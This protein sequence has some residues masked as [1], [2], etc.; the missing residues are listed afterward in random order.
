MPAW[1]RRKFLVSVGGERFLLK[2]AGLGRIGEDKLAMA[3]TL[4]SEGLVPEPLGLMHGF[5]VERWLEDAKPLGAHEKPIAE[6]GRYIAARANALPASSGS[7]A[8][9]E[10][11]LRMVRRN[12]SLEFGDDRTSALA[13]LEYHAS[14]L[15]RRIVRRRTDNKLDRHEW[16]RT[17]P[18]LLIK[19]D[20]LDHHQAHDLIGCQDVAW[21]VAGAIVEFDLDQNDCSAC[22][23][24]WWRAASK[25][26]ESCSIFA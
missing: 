24:C 1:E 16:L 15:E 25:S 3:R 20:A 17:G 9:I 19:T 22:W 5:I 6:I 7:G 12:I 23:A 8:S 11:L 13:H 18:G 2:F 14:S 10:D 4:F 26:S 21:D